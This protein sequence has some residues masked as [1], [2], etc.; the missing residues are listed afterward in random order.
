MAEWRLAPG[1]QLLLLLWLMNA[2][3]NSTP[4]GAPDAMFF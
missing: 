1:L 3:N 2:N 4:A